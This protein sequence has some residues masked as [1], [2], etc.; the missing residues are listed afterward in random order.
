MNYFPYDTLNG[1]LVEQ[2]L[3]DIVGNEEPPCEANKHMAIGDI[4]PR[5]DEVTDVVVSQGADEQAS[6]DVPNS[7][8]EQTPT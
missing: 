3:I 1:S 5:E 6:A 7:E 4:R 8:G 2:D